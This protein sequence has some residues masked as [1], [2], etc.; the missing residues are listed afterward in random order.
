MR[1]VVASAGAQLGFL[2]LKRDDSLW[3]EAL[4]VV[5]PERVEVGLHTP[6]DA[7]S[8]LAA[9]MIHYVARS[10]ETVVLGEATSAPR[11]ASDPYIVR[12]RPKSI[13][14][15]ALLHQ[16]RLVGIVYLENNV[17]TNVF[18]HERV[19]LLRLISSQAAISVENAQLYSNLQAATEKLKQS[20]E[21]L[22]QQVAQRTAQLSK[23]LN[24][25][26]SE[27]D[28]ARK[29]QTVLLPTDAKIPGY[30][31]TAIM[32]PAATVGGDYYDVFQE[33]GANWLL[34]GDV[35]GH[36][37]SAGLCMM[38]VQTA[39]RAVA[40]TLQSQP[41]GR[42]PAEMLTL[43]NSAIHR[44][45]SEIG[46]DHYMT[47][48][49]FCFQEN[50]IRYAG[51]HQDILVFRAAKRKIERIETRGV[52]LGVLP[53]VEGMLFE[54]QLELAPDDVMLLFTDGVTEAST[55]KRRYLQTDGLESM[56]QE[57]IPVA[58]GTAQIVEFILQRLK[59]YIIKDDI[60]LIAVKKLRNG[61]EN[62]A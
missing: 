12:E 51:L 7:R 13:L 23:A 25:L 22:E 59:D 50:Q 41:N 54:D 44:N 3:V 29:I 52:W 10:H 27:M 39:V 45:L 1:V 21:N 4:I 43:V 46:K 5:D 35:S 36:G 14:C 30:E 20:N 11:F 58:P 56:L 24:E 17:S 6:V 33:A 40:R 8:D 62:H 61:N 37:V 28:L 32:R 57:I 34:I 26:W 53:S 9:T 42:R 47:I 55:G 38:M 31:L 15:L 48:S 19:E 16:G 60:T 18:T 49:A 2:V